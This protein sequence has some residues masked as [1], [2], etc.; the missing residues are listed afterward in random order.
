VLANYNLLFASV[1]V[2]SGSQFIPCVTKIKVEMMFIVSFLLVILYNRYDVH[3]RFSQNF[4]SPKASTS[5]KCGGTC[6]LI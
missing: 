6:Y 5:K 3:K 2:G 1:S 4:D